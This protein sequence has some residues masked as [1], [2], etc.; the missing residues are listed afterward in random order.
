MPVRVIS[1]SRG[2]SG[3]IAAPADAL[4]EVLCGKVKQLN[5]AG[6]TEIRLAANPRKR[7]APEEA[8]SDEMDRIE[9]SIRIGGAR[10]GREDVILLDERGKEVGE[11][12]FADMLVSASDEA[13]AGARPR[14]PNAQSRCHSPAALELTS[15]R[16]RAGI[17]F[18]IGGPHGLHAD[19]RRKYRCI[20]L[21]KMVLN[22]HLARLVLLE[23]VRAGGDRCRHRRPALLTH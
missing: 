4:C 2:G 21:S 23:Q 17:V 1:V 20:S 10:A 18:V 16:R 13:Y 8:T 15:A 14:I 22:H 12:G 3:G 5:P 11:Y 9:A 7:Q 6:V 19:L